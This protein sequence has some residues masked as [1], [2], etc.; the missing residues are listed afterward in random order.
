[1]ADVTIA[2]VAIGAIGRSATL[3][4]AKIGLTAAIET[5]RSGSTVETRRTTGDVA[6]R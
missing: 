6:R 4:S 1:M 2:G 5:T 3:D